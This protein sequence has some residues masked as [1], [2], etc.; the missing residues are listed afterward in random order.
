M[1]DHIEDKHQ[2]EKKARKKK[3][4]PGKMPRFD[5][6]RDRDVYYFGVPFARSKLVKGIWFMRTVEGEYRRFPVQERVIETSKKKD[7]QH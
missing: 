6:Y 1:Q 5:R 3:S 4:A 7:L 2:P